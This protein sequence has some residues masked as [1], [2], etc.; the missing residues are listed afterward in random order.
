[1]M[2]CYILRLH[3]KLFIQKNI[4]S[5]C[6]PVVFSHLLQT[7]ESHRILQNVTYHHNEK[8]VSANI[9]TTAIIGS[10]TQPDGKEVYKAVYHNKT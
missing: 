1:M 3:T 9:K 2:N 4:E 7:T 6:I 8:C 10:R 5:L